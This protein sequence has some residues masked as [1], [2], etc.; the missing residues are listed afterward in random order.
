MTVG[1][2]FRVRDHGVVKPFAI[3]HLNEVIGMKRPFRTRS[4]TVRRG[5][6]CCLFLFASVSRLAGVEMLIFSQ[7]LA[8]V[9]GLTWFFVRGG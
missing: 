1:A 7:G 4:P 2:P 6:S 8:R 9:E 5:F 3:G